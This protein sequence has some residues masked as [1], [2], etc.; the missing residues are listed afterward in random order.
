MINKS[1]TLSS[2]LNVEADH[3]LETRP[4]V[5]SFATIADWCW[6]TTSSTKVPS[7]SLIHISE[8]TRLGMISY[9]VFCLKHEASK[10]IIK[11]K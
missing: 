2:A 11:Y 3:S 1:K 10:S 9:A 7:L 5:K 8:P 4:V 6:K